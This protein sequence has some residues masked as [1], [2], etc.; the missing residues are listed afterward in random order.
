MFAQLVSIPCLNISAVHFVAQW[1]GGN[2]CLVRELGE[3]RMGAF[4]L[5][6]GAVYVV[7]FANF[8]SQNLVKISTSL[9]VYL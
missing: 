2:S 7:I 9:Y 5:N 1:G 6:L 4:C 3:C 8:A